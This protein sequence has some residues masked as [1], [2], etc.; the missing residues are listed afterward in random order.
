S[1]SEEVNFDMV[2][3]NFGALNCIQPSDL[4]EV[5]QALHARIH[6][7]GYVVLVVMTSFCL[8]ESIYFLWK[9]KR[10]KA[11]RRWR[12]DS[13]IFETQECE[14]L[15]IWYYSPRKLYTLFKDY[16]TLHSIRP[17]GCFIPPSYM[18]PA[19]KRKP[20]LLKGLF[21][22]DRLTATLSPL[23]Y[24]SDHFLIVMQKK[25]NG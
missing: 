2:F 14:D 5:V 22:M 19:L 11:S 1:S 18:E 25:E 16:F 17:V 15:N 4:K 21:K 10:D 13:T 7:G 9:G 6:R 24:L 23:A 3:S 8:W 12:R 20:L